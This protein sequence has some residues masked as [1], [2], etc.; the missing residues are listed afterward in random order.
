[1][2]EGE[3]INIEDKTYILIKNIGSGGSACVWKAKLENEL[4]AI[5]FLIHAQNEKLERFKNEMSFCRKTNH[6]H[7]IKVI[8]LGRVEGKEFFNSFR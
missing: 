5:K 7:I 6:K 8:G 4:Y 3:L 2:K 1:M